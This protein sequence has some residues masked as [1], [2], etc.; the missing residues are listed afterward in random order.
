MG[1]AE[2]PE[3]RYRVR[4]ACGWVVE[5]PASVVVPA[6]IDHGGRIHNMA[7]TPEQVLAGAEVLEPV[8]EDGA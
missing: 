6:T 5:G 7:A 2:T 8:D 1:H 4:C 3:G